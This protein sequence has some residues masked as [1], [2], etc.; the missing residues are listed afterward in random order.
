M[1]L[2]PIRKLQARRLISYSDI[3]SPLIYCMCV[4]INLVQKINQLN[5]TYKFIAPFYYVVFQYQFSILLFEQ[6]LLTSSYVISP[7]IDYFFLCHISNHRLLLPMS[8]LQS[9]IRLGIHM[10][11]YRWDME[12]CKYKYCII[13]KNIILTLSMNIEAWGNIKR[14]IFHIC[15]FWAS[16]RTPSTDKKLNKY[17]TAEG[18]K[19]LNG[20]GF[21]LII[22]NKINFFHMS[23]LFNKNGCHQQ[24]SMISSD[25]TASSAA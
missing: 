4:Y 22:R 14:I 9:S 16:L 18:R 25:L 19:C 6:I 10:E 20:H 21:N 7:I 23:R 3:S 17:S 5:L 1:I 15:V 8:Y 13:V 12:C 2:C 24:L 11:I